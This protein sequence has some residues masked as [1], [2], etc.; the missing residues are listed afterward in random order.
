MEITQISVKKRFQAG[1]LAAIVSVVF[2]NVLAV[3]DI[4]IAY[5]PNGSMFA[6]MPRDQ[7]GRDVVHPLEQ[8]FRLALEKEIAKKLVE[9]VQ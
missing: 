7:K 8:N 9:N 3:H 1:G 2:D 5:R 6:V 4:K